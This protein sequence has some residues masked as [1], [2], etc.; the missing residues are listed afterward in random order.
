MSSSPEPSDNEAPE[1]VSFDSEKQAAKGRATV[2]QQFHAQEK[3]KKKEKNRQR[4]QALKERASSRP[5]PDTKGKS[6]AVVLDD[7][8]EDEDVEATASGPHDDLEA[9]MERAMKEAADEFESDLEDDEDEFGHSSDDPEAEEDPSDEDELSEKKISHKRP[10]YLPDHLFTAAFSQPEPSTASKRKAPSSQDKVSA[11]KRRRVRKAHNDIVAGGRTIR[12]LAP[13]S[14]ISSSMPFSSRIRAA[15]GT[16]KFLKR[17]LN[18]SGKAQASKLKGW[19]R[20][21]ANLGVLRRNGPAA[22]FVRDS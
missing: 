14:D 15:A 6:K 7:Q 11:K 21:S 8:I 12:S 3:Q 18:V 16:N 9:R 4:D 1:A 22:H 5:K 20:R 2:V 10:D 13:T 17:N 19:E